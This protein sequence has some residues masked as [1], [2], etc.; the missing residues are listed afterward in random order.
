MF[1]GIIPARAGFTSGCPAT[2]GRM[3]DHPRSRGV[4][5]VDR[6]GLRQGVL[7]HPR[8]RGVYP[9]PARRGRSSGGSSPLAR[10]LPGARHAHPPPDRIIPARAGFTPRGRFGR[11]RRRDHPRSRGVYAPDD[12][13]VAE[14]GG[15]SSPLARGLLATDVDAN[16]VPGIIPARAGFTPCARSSPTP[17]WDHPRSRGVYCFETS[18]AGAEDGSSPLA[19][20]LPTRLVEHGGDDRIIP[21]RAG[22]T[23]GH[24]G[25]GR[26]WRDHPRSRGVYTPTRAGR[27]GGRGSSPL[28]RGLHRHG[29]PAGPQCRIIPA[30]AGFTLDR[31]RR[32]PRHRDHPRSRGVYWESDDPITQDHGSSPLAR[33]L[34]GQ[35]S[36]KIGGAG[37]IPAR[38]GFTAQPRR[39]GP[40]LQDHPRS[41]GVYSGAVSPPAG[42]PG[43][44]PLARGL[45]PASPALTPTHRIIPAR[46]G[47]TP[48]PAHRLHGA[49][50]HPRSRGVYPPYGAITRACVGSS[51]L[52]RGLREGGFGRGFSGGIIPARAGFTRPST[53]GPPPPADHPRS[54]GVY[55]GV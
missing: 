45:L 50:D 23:T 55:L 22:F 8:S 30:R 21:A 46:A 11:R 43:S 14:E 49:L 12:G 29:P 53:T 35:D 17:A 40:D 24:R 19:R 6:H 7:D 51:P 37:I 27:R 9:S 4:Y 10:G 20:G 15:G 36:T 31:R 3:G 28:A 47:F 33:G 39:H 41:R 5:G 32:R 13:R 38:A 1:S 18:T 48:H 52:A 26:G 2:V 25:P 34:R 54:R 16:G 44:S 42:T